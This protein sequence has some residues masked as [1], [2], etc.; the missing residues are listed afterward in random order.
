ML[1]MVFHFF[2]LKLGV[3]LKLT[4]DIIN[5]GL[6]IFKFFLE[7]EFEVGPGN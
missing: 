3:S 1:F 7:A 4:Q 6:R 5:K 2:Q